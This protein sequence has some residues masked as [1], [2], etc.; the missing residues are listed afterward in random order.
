MKYSNTIIPNMCPFL[1]LVFLDLKR[2]AISDKIRIITSVKMV[3]FPTFEYGSLST[4]EDIIDSINAPGITD[5]IGTINVKVN[6]KL[7][8][9]KIPPIIVPLYC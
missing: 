6:N 8:R 1:N 3:A 4:I 7:H 2:I 5:N 9:V